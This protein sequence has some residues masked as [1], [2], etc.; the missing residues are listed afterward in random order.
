MSVFQCKLNNNIFILLCIIL[1]LF[2]K[3][4]V[5]KALTQPTHIDLTSAAWV[6]GAHEDGS[7]LYWDIMRLVYEPFGMKVVS[8]ITDYDHSVSL[9]KNGKKDAWLGSYLDE[10]T[11]VIYPKW[12]FDADVVTALYKK[13]SDLQWQGSKSLVGKNVGW[14]QGYNYHKYID[15]K[16]NIK[17]FKTREQAIKS[18]E[19]GQL[20]FFLEARNELDNEFIKHQFDA[21]KFSSHSL[22]NLNLFL[23]FAN[24]ERGKL[25]ADIFDMRFATLLESGEIKKLYNKWNWPIYPY[26]QLCTFADSAM[27]NC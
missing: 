27:V 17:E 10:K 22:M 24:N 18:L 7:G 13:S 26:T 14:I 1:T 2:F 8:N 20:D 21:T 4:N 19:N 9:V 25:L 16:F 6:N 3:V 11:D 15:V 12:H 5:A 23:G